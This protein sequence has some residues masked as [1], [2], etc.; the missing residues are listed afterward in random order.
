MHHHPRPRVLKDIDFELCY[1]DMSLL[2]EISQIRKV[3]KRV[4][5]LDLQCCMYSSTISNRNFVNQDH[6]D[7]AKG[8]HGYWK[9]YPAGDFS[10]QRLALILE[11]AAVGNEKPKKKRIRQNAKKREKKKNRRGFTVTLNR[12]PA[13]GVGDG[14]GARAESNELLHRSRSVFSVGSG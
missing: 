8:W 6:D 3:M 7:F 2:G 4:D 14:T 1:S 5:G 11:V 10:P 12:G 9:H 13:A